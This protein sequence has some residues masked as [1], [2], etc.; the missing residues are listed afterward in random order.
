MPNAPIRTSYEP[1]HRRKM[2][3][4][5][6]ESPES[7]A[8]LYFCASRIAHSTGD[9]VML[10]VVEPLPV[11]GFIGVREVHAEEQR[12]KAKALFRMWRTKLNA[13]GYESVATHEVIRE[14]RVSEAI[15]ELIQEDSDI[16][17]LVLGAA[18]DSRGP[19]PLV[20]ALATKMAGSF[21]IPITIVPGNMKL[22]ELQALA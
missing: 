4:I 11:E 21:P 22:E 3:V 8:A 5:V 17:I 2:L 16:A 12:N 9:I 14:G 18:V 20:T 10:Y 19:G 13:A 6:D 7:Q 1:G 15:V